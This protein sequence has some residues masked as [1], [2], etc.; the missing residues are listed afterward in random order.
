MIATV[1]AVG[2]VSASRSVRSGRFY[3]IRCMPL[4]ILIITSSCN[5]AMRER[6]RR[7]ISDGICWFCPT[8]KRTKSIRESSIFSK[9]RL[10]LNKWMLIIYW[11]AKQYPVTDCIDEAEVDQRSA[12]DI[13]QWLREV[14][15]TRLLRDPPIVLG[16]QGVIVQVDESLFRHKPK[17]GNGIKRRNLF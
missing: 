3:C 16:G 8:C 4:I 5:V 10:P 1:S 12:I 11:W 9:S 15:T 7:D 13:Y 2:G 14:C 17:V 6:K